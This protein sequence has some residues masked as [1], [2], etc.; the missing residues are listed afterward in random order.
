MGPRLCVVVLPM[1][2]WEERRDSEASLE[3]FG[4]EVWAI[5]F[6]ACSHDT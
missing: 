6:P 5:M 3:G 2:H 1:E 4:Q